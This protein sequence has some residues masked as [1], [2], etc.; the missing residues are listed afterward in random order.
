MKYS[1]HDYARA[2]ALAI[3]AAGT[4]TGVKGTKGAQSAQEKSTHKKSAIERN[5]LAL[6]RKNGDEV[7]LLKIVDEAARLLRSKGGERDVR[8]ES[9]RALSASQEKIVHRL[10]K[11][12][13]SVRYATNPDLI[14]GVKV[15]VND[16]IQFDGT[17]KAK[18]DT[19]FG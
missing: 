4:G 15:T 16:E 11:A 10:V 13:D 5:F 14:A 9:A 8:I 12:G 6:V 1:I 17:M 19:L 2:L 7:R 18:L 3:E